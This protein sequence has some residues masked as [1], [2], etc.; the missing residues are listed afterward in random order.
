MKKVLLFVATFVIATFTQ[1]VA[2]NSFSYQAVIRDNGEVIS[3]KEIA[4]RISLMQGSETYYQETQKT[5][6]NAY[7]NINI[8]VG[9]GTVISGSMDLVPWQTMQVM[10]KLEVDA[11]GGSDFVELGKVQIR[12]APYAMYAEKT[13]TTIQ[14]TDANSTE[15]I[16]AVKNSKGE[17]LFAVYEDGVKVYVDMDETG[18]KAAKSKFAV[19]GRSSSKAEDVDLFT[20][21]ANGTKVYVDETNDSKAAKSKFAVAGRSSSKETSELLTIDN[22]GST[23]Y[24]DDTT[25][26][27][28]AKS[29]FAV[30]GRSSS[31]AEA[32][33]MLTI[34]GEG[35]TVYVDEIDSNS[36]AAKSK[37]AVAGR[38]SSKSETATVLS[39][40]ANNSIF[41]VD[42]E[43]P[44]T[45]KAAKSKFAVAGRSSSKSTA[46]DMFTIDYV[47]TTVYID[48]TTTSKAAKSKFAVAGRSSSKEDNNYL[49]V[50]TD[51]T[52]F[53]IN[54]DADNASGFAV[55]GKSSSNA[56]LSMNKDSVNFKTSMYVTG[57]VQTASG[58]VTRMADNSKPSKFLGIGMI[59][60]SADTNT[61]N[62]NYTYYNS[63]NG[64][65]ITFTKEDVSGASES[66]FV[67][68]FILKNGKIYE[69]D[70]Y[71][72]IDNDGEING[73][74]SLVYRF[75]YTNSG[76][77]YLS[78]GTMRELKYDAQ[79]MDDNSVEY[80][81][82]D[83]NEIPIV[84]TVANTIS[85]YNSEIDTA[86]VV[87][88]KMNESLKNIVNKVFQNI[89]K[90][91]VTF[92]R[93]DIIECNEVMAGEDVPEPQNP[94][95]NP[96]G[97]TNPYASM[98]YDMEEMLSIVE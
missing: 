9:E 35:T 73:E 57:E 6:T 58:S 5:T 38:S 50:N 74:I 21:D 59:S 34:D 60:A 14:S 39:I 28:A 45:S 82:P 68:L 29:K 89:N 75:S 96:Q 17:L 95:E 66:K 32:T 79:P 78:E 19:A 41:Y 23:F 85:Q 90:S 70:N 40:D 53:Y 87:R 16:F 94:D 31:K 81:A 2:Q 44:T 20:I 27:K 11:A 43:E 3:S 69:P 71:S 92:D 30:A 62:L 86:G 7:G 24:V 61:I 64:E 33:Q 12:P 13:S 54:D 49:V 42:T 47:G 97:S 10:M 36:K 48:E 93:I 52:R 80:F 8:N 4:L 63:V 76:L 98:V 91:Q 22:S 67:G 51:S 56:L 84:A 88:S 83:N 46:D 77:F 72:N 18:S 37:F 25:T 65:V 1:V 15:P 55:V 26:S